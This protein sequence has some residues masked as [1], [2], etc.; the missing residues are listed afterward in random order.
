MGISMCWEGV[1]ILE[2]EN[3]NEYKIC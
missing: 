1:T 3:P 2:I